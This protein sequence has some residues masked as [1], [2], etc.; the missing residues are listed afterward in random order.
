MSKIFKKFRFLKVITNFI[1][2]NPVLSIAFGAAVVTSVI[3]PVDK[4]T[5]SLEVAF[6]NNF[7]SFSKESSIVCVVAVK[8][9]KI[10]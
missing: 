9:V 1:K 4:E 6:L 8:F 10:C 3:I 5:Y 7:A 2:K